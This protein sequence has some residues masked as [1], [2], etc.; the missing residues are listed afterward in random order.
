[1]FFWHFSYVCMLLRQCRWARL[2]RVG[3]WFAKSGVQNQRFLLYSTT[4]QNKHHASI[5][6]RTLLCANTQTHARQHSKSSQKKSLSPI[7]ICNYRVHQS[8]RLSALSPSST[9]R[10][11]CLAHNNI[12]KQEFPGSGSRCCYCWWRHCYDRIWKRTSKPDWLTDWLTD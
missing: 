6:M 11:H 7:Y 1:M 4:K 12:I 2:E 3:R 5:F 10:V 9:Q 8:I